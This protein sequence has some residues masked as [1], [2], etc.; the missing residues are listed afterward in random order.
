MTTCFQ[1][2][3]KCEAIKLKYEGEES[4]TCQ[5]LSSTLPLAMQGLGTCLYHLEGE[6][7]KIRS[8]LGKPIYWVQL[9]IKLLS[10]KTQVR[11]GWLICCAFAGYY[12]LTVVLKSTICKKPQNTR[13]PAKD[14][15]AVEKNNSVISCDYSLL[16]NSFLI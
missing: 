11:H 6:Q 13:K 12:L 16:E 15:P 7:R 9:S 4:K 5:Q 10:F 14:K 1:S 8:C 3:S 2:P